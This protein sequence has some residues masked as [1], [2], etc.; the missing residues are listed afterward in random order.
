[1]KALGI[2]V[3]H[4]LAVALLWAGSQTSPQTGW[5]RTDIEMHG[6]ALLILGVIAKTV[7]HWLTLA[8]PH[9]RMRLRRA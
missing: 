4:A 7:G 9:A 8:A 2:L 6:C 3:V 1:M 5:P